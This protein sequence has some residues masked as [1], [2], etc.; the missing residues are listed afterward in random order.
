MR[1]AVQI[2]GRQRYGKYFG[3]FQ[4]TMA[5]TFGS[6]DYFIHNWS[7]SRSADELKVLVQ[8]P[9]N[10]KTIVVEP[11]KP[12]FVDPKW[13][14]PYGNVFNVISMI[15]GVQQVN[16]QRKAYEA[17]NGFQ[18]DLI[19]RARSDIKATEFPVDPAWIMDQPDNKIFVGI[20][21][22]YLPESLAEVQDQ[23]AFGKPAA[24]DIYASMY[25]GVKVPFEPLAKRSK[26]KFHPETYVCW[27]C[28]KHGLEIDESTFTTLLEND[29]IDRTK[30][31]TY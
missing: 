27:W 1:V 13:L 12:F 18:Y 7:D 11:Q 5:T 6:V 20:R 15:Y 24:M 21:P 26:P 8:F 14:H 10:A 29:H 16:E 4:T 30:R 17:E 3:D 9:H 2:S 25:S 28:K 23:V 19:V 31:A 22:H